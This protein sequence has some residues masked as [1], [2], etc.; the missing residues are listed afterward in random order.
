MICENMEEV[1]SHL[2]EKAEL[3]LTKVLKIDEIKELLGQRVDLPKDKLFD[4]L[5]NH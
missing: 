2:E 3:L 1:E 4:L 5:K